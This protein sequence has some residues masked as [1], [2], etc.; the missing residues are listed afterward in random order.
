MVSSR[1]VSSRLHDALDVLV[2]QCERAEA[3][4]IAIT[5]ASESGIVELR[6]MRRGLRVVVAPPGVSAVER[7][8]MGMAAATGDIVAIVDDESSPDPDL[9]RRLTSRYEGRQS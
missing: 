9:V 8:M 5:V 1:A 3:E 4:L 6:R 7:R 2:P